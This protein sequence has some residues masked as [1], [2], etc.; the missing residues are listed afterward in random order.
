MSFLALL[1][2]TAFL[3]LLQLAG[4]AFA[5]TL[6]G[7]YVTTVDSPLRSGPGAQY[8]VI[9]T[10]PKGI[11]INVVGREGYWLQIESRHG[12]PPGY[13][14]ER[15]ASR[16]DREQAPAA[17]TLASATAAGEY[18]VIADADLRERPGSQEKIVARLPAGIKI[19][20][21]RADGEWL[22]VESKRGG[23]PGYIESRF[24]ERWSAR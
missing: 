11:K 22:R 7:S 12:G 4:A 5:Q 8:E 16:I 1:R 3:L 14:D 21:I 13:L 23:R 2:H 19:H 15:Y 20:V 17:H 9:A 10:L 18:R 6:I 24:V